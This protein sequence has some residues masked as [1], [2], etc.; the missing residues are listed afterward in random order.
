VYPGVHFS[1][2]IRHSKVDSRIAIGAF[3]VLTVQSLIA[4]TRRP[5]HGAKIAD[6]RLV[7]IF[8]IIITFVLGTISFAANVKYTEMIWIDLRD[9]PGGP[10]ALIQNAWGYRINVLALCW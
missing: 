4:L 8:Y 3:L 9:A 5:R 6:H 7:L 10:L 2:D 1:V